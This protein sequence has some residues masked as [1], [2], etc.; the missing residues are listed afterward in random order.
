[1]NE[2][3]YILD[4]FLCKQHHPLSVGGLPEVLEGM[5]D[6]INLKELSV[7]E[8]VEKEKAHCTTPWLTNA[9]YQ[10]DGLM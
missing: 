7:E 4:P 6:D 3:P 9:E 1:M 10:R 2:H 8:N 5:R